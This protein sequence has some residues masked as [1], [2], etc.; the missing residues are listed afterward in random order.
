MEKVLT[1]IAEVT[2]DP[3]GYVAGLKERKK[4]KVI[5]CF[6]MHIPEEI[7]HAADIIPVVIWR[8]NEPVTWGHAHVPP[9]DCGI[10]RSFVDDA[11]RGKLDFM[12]GMVFH[13]RQ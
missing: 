7:I 8:G 10:T 1:E 13:I 6:P 4:K 9:Y 2:A 3:Y 5:G 11:V 12:D